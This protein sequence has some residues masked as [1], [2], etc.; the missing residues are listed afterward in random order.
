MGQEAQGGCTLL[1]LLLLLLL[2]RQAWGCASG[3]LVFA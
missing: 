2:A 3:W 1:L